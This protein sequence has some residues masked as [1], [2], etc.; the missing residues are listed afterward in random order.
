MGSNGLEYIEVTIGRGTVI[1]LPTSNQLMHGGN[2]NGCPLM[3]YNGEVAREYVDGHGVKYLLTS[4]G[5][6]YSFKRGD[7][8]K[9]INGAYVPSIFK[10]LFSKA[11]LSNVYADYNINAISPTRYYHEH[12]EQRLAYQKA[13]RDNNIERVRAIEKRSK[14]KAKALKEQGDETSST[15]SSSG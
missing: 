4:Y 9:T 7:L 5:R 1:R 12:R 14:A 8:V 6:I 15:S 3:L 13:Y 11:D 10:A 2:G